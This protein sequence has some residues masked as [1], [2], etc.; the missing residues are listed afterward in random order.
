MFDFKF[1]WC[2]EMECGV[3]IIDEQHQI[4]FRIGRDIEQLVMHGCQ[5]ATTKQLLDIVCELREYT[6]YH[7]YTEEDL[8]AKYNYPKMEEHKVA[9]KAFKSEILALDLP[10]LGKHPEQVLPKVK[11]WLQDFLFNHVMMEDQELGR[12]LTPLMKE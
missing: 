10:L 11:S 3:P 9:H 8:M 5:N 1:D 6:S 2:K 12:Y 4:L 7:F